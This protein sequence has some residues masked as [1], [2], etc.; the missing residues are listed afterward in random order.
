VRQAI[1]HAINY[2]DVAS[3][4]F[5]GELSPMVGPEYP[6]QQQFY[7]L[8]NLP[9]YNYNLTLARQI[10]NQSSIDTS[11]FP[12]LEFR[13]ETGCAAC[14]AAAQVVQGNLADIGIS[15]DVEVT[16]GSQMGPP[17]VGGGS[18]SVNLQDAQTISQLTWM[19]GLTFA[20]DEPTPADPWFLWVSNQ[21]ASANYAIYSNPV[22]QACV[23]AFSN[24]S[25]TPTLTSLCTQAQAQIYH[26]APYVWLGSVKL[27]FGG[28]SVVWQKNIVKSLLV[29]PD[30]SG[31]AYAVFNTVTFVG[32]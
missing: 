30:Y 13:V 10:L 23:D 17:L 1:E 32:S 21:S 5:F 11:K 7:N 31:Q 28:G 29:D 12:A 20:P 27:L 15:V 25:S 9:P 16:P 3:K 24:G 18:Y 2:T 26:D 14:I 6:A 19:G 8:G 22:V 4:A